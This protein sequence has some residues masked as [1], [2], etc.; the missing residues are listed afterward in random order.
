MKRIPL[1]DRAGAVVAHALVDNDVFEEVG[2]LR[3]SLHS[4]GYAVRDGGRTYLHRVVMGLEPGD[5]READHR[6]RNRLN[7]QR[8]NLRIVTKGQQRQNARGRRSRSEH[9]GVDF[10]HRTGRWRARVHLH[11]RTYSLG[12]WPTEAEAAAA[13][14]GA[15]RV[16]MPFAVEDG[17]G[18][19]KQGGA[20]Q[21]TPPRELA[22]G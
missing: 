19:R 20:A 12:N 6:D 13:A 5:G 7:N 14:S 15:R 10:E 11:G 3:W 17:N 9:R 1:R 21:T 18:S 4:D 8:S 2:D 16:L 22:A